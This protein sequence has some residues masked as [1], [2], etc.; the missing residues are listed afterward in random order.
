MERN[1]SILISMPFKGLTERTKD[2]LLAFIITIVGIIGSYLI[3]GRSITPDS[4]NLSSSGFLSKN[5]TFNSIQNNTLS[6]RLELEKLG[7]LI[8]QGNFVTN[9]LLNFVYLDY[10]SNQKYL[11]DFG[12]GIRQKMLNS[13]IYM[14][15][16]QPGLYV[17]Q[18][19]SFIDEK[20]VL[21][22]SQTINIKSLEDKAVSFI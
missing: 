20:W 18:L 14:K 13:N 12:N 11:I 9:E 15:F 17:V 1:L 3:L 5:K 4:E 7:K 8:I 2:L 22:A 21:V 19:Y 6:Q 16:A 10:N